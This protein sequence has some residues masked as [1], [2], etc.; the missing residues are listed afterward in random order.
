MWN[1]K[2]GEGHTLAEQWITT[3]FSLQTGWK[4]PAPDI[5]IANRMVYGQ[6][7]FRR[8]NLVECIPLRL[9]AILVHLE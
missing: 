6:G 2:L 7:T 1:A 5:M 9:G 8:Q 3:R 4:T